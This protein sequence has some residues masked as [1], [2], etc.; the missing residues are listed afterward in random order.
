MIEESRGLLTSEAAETLAAHVFSWLAGQPE[1]L[2]RFMAL[3][4]LDPA[5]MRSAAADPG[6]LAGIL[7]FLTAEEP[8]LLAYAATAGISPARVTTARRVLNQHD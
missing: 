2:A 8:L 4:G 5:T 6:F 7:D 3:T 1:A